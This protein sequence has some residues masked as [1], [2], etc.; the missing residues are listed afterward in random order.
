MNT[1]EKT[2]YNLVKN[3]TFLKT[4]IRNTYQYLLSFIPKK[5]KISEYKIIEREG[6]FFGFHDKIPWSH[7]DKLL[8]AHKFTIPNRN[9]TNKDEI[10]IG[11]FYG[12][13]YQEFKSLAKTKSWN[14][15]QGSMLQWIGKE[16]NIIF[17]YWNGSKNISRIINKEGELIKELPVS[18]AAVN[19]T[20]E[21]ALSYSFDRLNIG[22]YGYGYANVEDEVSKCYIPSNSG[23]SIV[24]VNTGEIKLLFSIRDIANI[25][26]V[27]SKKEA[28]HF[29]SHCLFAP[30]GKNFVFLHRWLNKGR[31]INSRMIFTDFNGDNLKILPTSGMVSHFTWINNSKLFV[32]CSTYDKGDGYYLFDITDL[33]YEKIDSNIYP[34]DGHPQFSTY[35]SL[36]V[37]DTY[38]DK[39]RMQEI[40]TYNIQRAEKKIIAKLW[41]PLNFKDANRCD[42]HPRWNR[43]GTL[44]CFDSAHTKTR[45]LC[46]IKLM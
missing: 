45:S 46:T 39:F 10:E 8:L 29:F 32:F 30:D 22:H 23:L 3:N 34:R 7:D 16:D 38:P 40:S 14:W 31:R 12:E 42:L 27:K 2:I 36:I 6:Y 11:Y 20:G 25:E 1:F 17:N 9:I 28:Y 18:I 13:D 35:N 15:Q 5:K 4:I 26:G 19:D 43:T 33:S 24:D 41:S 44:I 37:T 21:Y